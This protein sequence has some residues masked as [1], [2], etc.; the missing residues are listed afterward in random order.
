[1]CEPLWAPIAVAAG[2]GLALSAVPDAPVV[3]TR[4]R[5][6]RRRLR[7]LAERLLAS[8]PRLQPTRM[9]ERESCGT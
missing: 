9:E 3:T 5:R 2:R 8:R 1:M 7:G 6:G 4:P